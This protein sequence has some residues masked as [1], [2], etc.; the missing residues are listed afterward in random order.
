MCPIGSR[1][2]M[3]PFRQCI[4]ISI[5]KPVSFYL[6]YL[7]IGMSMYTQASDDTFLPSTDYYASY[8][9]SVYHGSHGASRAICGQKKKKLLYPGEE[10][11]RGLYLL[12]VRSD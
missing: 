7:T 3:M 2:P 10:L 8:F 6:T 9:H 4:K 5:E 1:L 11:D 12:C